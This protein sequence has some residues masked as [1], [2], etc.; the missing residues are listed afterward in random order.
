MKSE[1][2]ITKNVELKY[3]QKYV[4]LGVMNIRNIKI[5]I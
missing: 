1:L 3:A 5:N 2:F 4:K